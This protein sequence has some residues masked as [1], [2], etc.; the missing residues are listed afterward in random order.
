MT[1]TVTIDKTDAVIKGLRLLADSSVLVGIPASDGREDGPLS[2]AEIGFIHEHGSPVNNLPARPFLVPGV[3]ASRKKAAGQFREAALAALEGDKDKISAGL[4]KAGL[5]A[6]ASVRAK[7]VDNDWPALSE[8][9]LKKRPIKGHKKNGKPR[10]GKSREERGRTNP[11]IDTNQ[12]R[13]SVTYIVT[14][15]KK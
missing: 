1:V 13:E 6:Q 14:K 4:D 3:R 2:N 12:L 15:G 11:L 5:I 8:K 10:Y 9:T 7:F